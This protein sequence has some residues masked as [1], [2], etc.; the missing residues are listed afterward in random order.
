[1]ADTKILLAEAGEAQRLLTARLNAP[2]SQMA[3]RTRQLLE[4]SQEKLTQLIQ[5]LGERKEQYIR[6]TE[7]R[8]EHSRELI[9]EL[10]REIHLAIERLDQAGDLLPA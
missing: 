6:A 9:T 2:P 1:V 8:I 3:E 4:T 10:R 7:A 5:D